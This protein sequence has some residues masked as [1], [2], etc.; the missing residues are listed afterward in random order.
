MP[1]TASMP[2]HQQPEI[3]GTT[4][5]FSVPGRRNFPLDIPIGFRQVLSVGFRVAIPSC[6]IEQG[7]PGKPHHLQSL[8]PTAVLDAVACT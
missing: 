2:R 4:G 1:G 6:Q 5:P 8:P 3:R 7:V